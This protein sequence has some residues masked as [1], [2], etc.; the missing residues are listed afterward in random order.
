[1]DIHSED[2]TETWRS[3]ASTRYE[4]FLSQRDKHLEVHG[5]SI[6]RQ[7]ERF[8]S[9]VRQLFDAGLIGGVRLTGRRRGDLEQHLLE[10]RQRASL[11][12]F[13]AEG[14]TVLEF[15]Y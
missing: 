11:A 9:S 4:R 2:L 1:M 13:D 8:Y 12:G 5:E 3:W 7:R 14:A 10:E 15:D 6:T